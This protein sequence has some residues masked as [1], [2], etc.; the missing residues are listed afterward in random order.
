MLCLNWKQNG[1]LA[2]ICDFARNLK[3]SAS[4]KPIFFPPAIYLQYFIESFPRNAI[5]LG[6]QDISLFNGGA[7]TGEISAKMFSD[8][9][10]SYALVGHSEIRNQRL[11]TIK[12][13]S[14][15]ISNITKNNI[16]PIL[17]I[18]ET[19]DERKSG[20]WIKNSIAVTK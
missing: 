18:G 8:F 4:V 11:E 1:S 5:Q 14:I 9:S 19:S 3:L 13:T 15:K 10:T 7:N 12:Q 16:T 2:M 20:K 6:G 17:C